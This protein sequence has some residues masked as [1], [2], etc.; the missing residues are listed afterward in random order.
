MPHVTITTPIQASPR[1]MP[2]VP[3]VPD[4]NQ[5]VLI[6]DAEG[7]HA[8]HVERQLRRAGIKNPVVI[9]D[10]GDDLHA[11]LVDPAQKDAPAP[12]VLFLDPKMPGANGY[13][14]VRWVKR[15]KCGNDILVVIFSPNEKP[16]DEQSATELGVHHFL[17]K[18]T[19]LSGLS[20]VV[21]HLGGTPLVE[22]KSESSALP[23][24]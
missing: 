19:G 12:C 21:E 10:N 5:P 9:F 17:K 3:H 8:S 1:T 7:E 13:D 24:K 6:A 18:H 22:P 2:D 20:A 16:E 23:V 4:E 14:P 15:E 11:H